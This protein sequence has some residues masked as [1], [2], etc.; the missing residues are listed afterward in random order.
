MFD[1]L[2]FVGGVRSSR[3][4]A[5]V[6][7]MCLVGGLSGVGLVGTGLSGSVLGALPGSAWLSSSERGDVVLANGANG[8]GVARL[9]VPGAEGSRMSVVQR[10]GFACVRSERADGS[11][12]VNCVDDATFGGAGSK[13]VMK[14]QEVVRTGAHAYMVDAAKGLVRPLNPKSLAA[15]GEVLEFKAPIGTVADDE[16]RLLVLELETSLASVVVGS[17]AGEPVV[18]GEAKGDVF[19][20]LVDGEFAVVAQADSRVTLFKDGRVDRRVGLP[21]RLG[22]LLVPGEVDGG[23]LPLLSRSDSGVEVV[24]LDTRTDKGRRVKVRQVL[25][26]ASEVFA[27]SAGLFVPDVASGSVVKIDTRSGETESIEMGV[28]K[29]EGNL[30]VFTKDGRLWVN[31]PNGSKAVVIDGRGERHE[32]NKYDKDIEEVDPGW[33]P[34]VGSSGFGVCCC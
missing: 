5:S 20:V 34:A 27:T 22:S 10:G 33:E 9:G 12:S 1:V 2:G 21:G 14:G 25:P 8:V 31:N 18:I 7:V 15:D 23:E 19:G 13:N 29:G 24:V 6:A 26:K 30:E 17:S 28:G 32:V 4:V 3:G 16:G 11:A